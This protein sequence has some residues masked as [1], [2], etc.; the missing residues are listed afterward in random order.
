MTL[1]PPPL[2]QVLSVHSLP[3]TE[4]CS[5][6]FAVANERSCLSLTLSSGSTL[7][8]V[9]SRN[10]APSKPSC[11]CS[12]G[13][14]SCSGGKRVRGAFPVGR[15]RPTASRRRGALIVPRD[16]RVD[17]S[18]ARA[19]ARTPA[20]ALAGRQDAPVPTLMTE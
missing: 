6:S 19:R 17:R 16:I 9:R 5:N 15:F 3:L 12:E 7:E 4:R 14:R 2:P 13:P 18:L 20:H 11:R 8:G 1:S 10:G